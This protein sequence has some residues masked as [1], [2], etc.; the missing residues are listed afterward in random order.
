MPEKRRHTI[1]EEW[2]GRA[3][4]YS[5][6][7]TCSK[8]KKKWK[9]SLGPVFFSDPPSYL[10]HNKNIISLYTGFNVS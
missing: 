2:M 1:K 8:K 9:S 6:V 3:L 10:D 7:I 5:T 4:L